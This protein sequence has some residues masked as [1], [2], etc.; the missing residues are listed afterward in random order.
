MDFFGV[1]LDFAE[2][3]CF[4]SLFC[5][6]VPKV[7]MKMYTQLTA[8]LWPFNYSNKLNGLRIPNWRA[9]NRPVDFVH[10]ELK[11]QELPGRNAAEGHSATRTRDLQNSKSGGQTI[12]SHTWF[13][14]FFLVLPLH[15]ARFITLVDPENSAQYLNKAYLLL[16]PT[17]GFWRRHHSIF[18]SGIHIIVGLLVVLAVWPLLKYT[19]LLP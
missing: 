1:A 10:E 13:K 16:S 2:L 17:R 6:T 11:K 12:R 9:G 18:H 4:F 19:S 7:Q 8:S 14:S 5:K 3:L 15:F